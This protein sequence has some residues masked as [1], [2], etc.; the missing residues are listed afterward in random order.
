MSGGRERK[1][2]ALVAHIMHPDNTNQTQSHSSWS[3]AAV[4]YLVWCGKCDTQ[5]YGEGERGRQVIQDYSADMSFLWTCYS[6]SIVFCVKRRGATPSVCSKLSSGT[7][8]WRTVDQHRR[9]DN[10]LPFPLSTPS[11]FSDSH[12]LKL[13]FA[14]FLVRR[15]FQ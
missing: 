6:C 1:S 12:T 2:W 4:C 13:C 5:A 8:Q 14:C 3:W 9:R 10:E 15:A 11:P 7:H